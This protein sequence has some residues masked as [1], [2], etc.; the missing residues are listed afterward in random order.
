MTAS[1][2]VSKRTIQKGNFKI[3][4]NTEIIGV[5]YSGADYRVILREKISEAL[6]KS[7]GSELGNLCE[8]LFTA[9]RQLDEDDHEAPLSIHLTNYCFET[10]GGLWDDALQQ[11]A[12]AVANTIMAI[13]AQIAW[14]WEGKNKPYQL[15]KGTPYYFLAMSFV[16]SGNV[17]SG[18]VMAHNALE[19]DRRTYPLLGRDATEAPA[20]SFAALDFSNLSGSMLPIVQEMQ[21]YL[22]KYLANHNGS[23]GV[24]FKLAD[25][26][27]KFLKNDVLEDVKFFF[28]YNLML[29][30]NMNKLAHPRLLINSFT[31]LRNIDLLFNLSLIIDKVLQ[32]KYATEYM[33][34]GVPSVLRDVDGIPDRDHQSLL[35][36]LTY[37]DGREFKVND[38]PEIVIPA[39]INGQVRYRGKASSPAM[40]AFLSAWNLRNYGAHNVGGGATVTTTYFTRALNLLF[41]ALFFSVSVLS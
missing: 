28:V 26:S 13:A 39:L 40:T 34:N 25:F 11:G 6:S 37:S 36:A 9:A 38:D 2:T 18:F 7:D 23:S 17:D 21:K 10:F 4:V 15:H 19:E 8:V 14:E 1:M 31:A 5:W 35:Q 16:L 24:G 22:E 20:Y 33:R 12:G 27:K 3:E 30:I 29:I 41:S 32:H